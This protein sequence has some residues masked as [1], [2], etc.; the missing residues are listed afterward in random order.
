MDYTQI[1]FI[2]SF[3][4][5]AQGIENIYFTENYYEGNIIYMSHNVDL[6]F[7]MLKLWFQQF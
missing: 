1:Y 4:K 2:N 7:G 5:L 3:S 6:L